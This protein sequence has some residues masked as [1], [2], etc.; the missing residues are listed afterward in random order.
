M[1]FHEVYLVRFMLLP[2]WYIYYRNGRTGLAYQCVWVSRKHGLLLSQKLCLE[3][4]IKSL[5]TSLMPL[6]STFITRRPSPSSFL[7]IPYLLPKYS[8]SNPFW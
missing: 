3:H 2:H 7:V 8:F 1:I 6:T 4:P 5:T